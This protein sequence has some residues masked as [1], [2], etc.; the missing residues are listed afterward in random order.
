MPELETAESPEAI[1]P[2]TSSSVD[3]RPETSSEGFGASHNSIVQTSWLLPNDDPPAGGG[4]P[5]SA[6][7]VY[8]PRSDL[9]SVEAFFDPHRQATEAGRVLDVDPTQC[10]E[11]PHA[12]VFRDTPYPSATACAKCHRQIYEEWAVSNHAYASISPMFTR[13]E[14]TLNRLSQGTVGYFCLRCHAPV[15]TTMGLR[16]DQPL[17][18]G[19]RVF[20]EGVTCVACHRVTEQYGKV[21]GERRME[22]GSIVEPVVGAGDGLG[23]ERTLRDRDR[24]LVRDT[25]EGQGQA[26]HRRAIQFEQ[27]SRS[28]FCVSCHQVAVYP[29]IKL[30]VVWDQYIASPAYREGVT[31]QDCH[32]GKIPGLAEGYS[33][34]PCAIIDGRPVLPERKHSNHLFYGP[35]YSVAHPGVFPH[36]EQADR[37]T[38][39]EWL[40]FDWRAG[41]GTD[42]FEQALE[43]GEFRC[44]FPP[45]WNDVEVRYEAREVLET[46]FKAL[47]YK[48]ETRR[49]VMENGS[50]IDGPFFRDGCERE[51]RQVVPAGKP[52]RFHYTVTNLNSGHNLPTASLGAQPQ[53]WLNVV[54]ID[55]RGQRVWE[56]GYLD[57]QG[58]LAD[59][60]SDDV[61][62]GKLPHDDQ[63]F[64]LQ[65]K[66]LITNVKGTDREVYLPVNTDVDQIPFLRPP[67]LPVSVLNHPPLIRM[68][69]HSLPPL[70]SREARYRI[71]GDRLTIP[72]WYRLSVRMR[73]RAEPP[74]FMRFVEATPE[75]IRRMTEEIQDCHPY[76]V[77]FEVE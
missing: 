23:V 43:R 65:T 55:P 33:V 8:R 20:R 5:T 24:F 64:N 11:D 34:G 56:T 36:N 7:H 35:G 25:L 13:F 67:G 44:D 69:A 22:P 19:P 39:Q 46:N 41:W 61:L 9:A 4:S 52:L 2:S 14:D 49:Q 37:W 63:L 76:T 40:L 47:A 16:R 74:Y 31:C 29:N 70:G 32:M 57:S 45:T 75:M 18:D 53:L 30:E 77:T 26:M 62:T 17:V 48:R 73:S 54:L 3:V 10:G 72:G 15:A 50:R 28:D 71:P 27:L 51:G 68:E 21:N 59:L 6:A 60:Q 12:E 38:V 58:D 66:F 42:A 1:A